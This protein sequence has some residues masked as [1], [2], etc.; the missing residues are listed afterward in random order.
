MTKKDDHEP[1]FWDKPERA[2]HK[3]STQTLVWVL[4][5]LALYF[6]LMILLILSKMPEGTNALP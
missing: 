2:V 4:I 1:K 5:G 3:V 6:V